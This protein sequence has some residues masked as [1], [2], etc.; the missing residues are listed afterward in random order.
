VSCELAPMMYADS[1]EYGPEYSEYEFYCET[2]GEY[3]DG[4]CD[5]GDS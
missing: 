2:C 4:P 3:V 5:E 1:E